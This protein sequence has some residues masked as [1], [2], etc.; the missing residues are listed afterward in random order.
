MKREQYELHAAVEQ[1][2]WWFVA[3]RQI[4]SHLARM[5]LGN[6]QTRIVVDDAYHTAVTVF[7][8]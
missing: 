3:R 2:H 5:L 4:V 6:D 7:L 1:R 8:M